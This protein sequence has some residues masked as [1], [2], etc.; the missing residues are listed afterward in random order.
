MYAS[1]LNRLSLSSVTY[2]LAL[3]TYTCWVL[4]V[5][6]NIVGGAHRDPSEAA[7]FSVK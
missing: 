7:N 6:Y 4:S 1:L 3:C 2:E 5:E